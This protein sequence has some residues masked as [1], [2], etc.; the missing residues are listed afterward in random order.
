MQLRGRGGKMKEKMSSVERLVPIPKKKCRP[1][2][3]RIRA[4]EIL[5]FQG[6]A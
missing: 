3:C 6:P 2:S 5:L 1:A 4:V